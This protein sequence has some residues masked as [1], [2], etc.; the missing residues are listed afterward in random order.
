MVGCS[1]TAARAMLD[2]MFTTYG[3]ITPVDLD[4]NFKA[5]CNT[6]DPQQPVETLFKKIQDSVYYYESGLAPIG[7]AQQISDDCT[8]I[9]ATGRFMSACCH[10]EKYEDDKTWPTFKTHFAAAYLQYK[11]IQ[12]KLASTSGYHSAKAAVV[13]AKDEDEMTEA[14]IGVLSNLATVTEADRSVVSVLTEAN[15]RFFNQL[16]H[17]STELKAIKEFLKKERIGCRFTPSA[18]Y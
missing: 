12:G 6:W 10:W 7:E 14:A 3:S 5:M 9:F 1:N 8:N 18:N 13:E 11:Q 2:Y 15:S 16:D 17:R 4:C